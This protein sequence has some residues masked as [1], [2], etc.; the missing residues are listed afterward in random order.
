MHWRLLILI[1]LLVAAGGCVRR[2]VMGPARHL[3][4]A[5]VENA[6]RAALANAHECLGESQPFRCED[7]AAQQYSRMLAGCW[8]TDR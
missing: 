1:A 3:D 5:C 2:G 6:R 7:R 8:V 4:P